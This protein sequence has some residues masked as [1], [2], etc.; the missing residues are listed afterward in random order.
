MKIGL[1][2]HGYLK[3]KKKLFCNCNAISGVKYSEPNS[4]ICPICTAQ[5]GSKPLLPNEDAIKK[6]IKIGLILNCKINEECVWQRKHYDWPDLPKGFQSTISGTYAKPIGENGSFL[7][8]RIR[9]V[10]L[11]EDPAA[12]NPQTGEIDYNRSGLPLIEIVTEPDFRSSKQVVEWLKQ[13]ISTLD[14]IKII[15]KKAGIKADVNVSTSGERV[16]VK[17]VNSLRNIQKT[18]EYEIL[19]QK[20]EIPTI[21]ETRRFDELKGTTKKMRDKEGAED[22]RFLFEPDLPK[23]VLNKRRVLEIKSS[24]PEMPHEKVKKLISK[25]KIPE[26]SAEILTKKLEIVEFFEKVVSKG[27]LKLALRWVTEELLSVL[28]YNKK[29][30]EDVEIEAEHFLELLELLDKDKITEHQAREILRSWIPK[31]FFPSKNL[32]GKE[33]IV[34]EEELENFV[35]EVLKNFPEAVQDYK[36][37]KENALNFLIGQIMKKSKGRADNKIVEKILKRS[38]I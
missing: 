18:I 15:N 19:R 28:N 11:E 14:Y 13:L 2:I 9:E 6:S 1:E 34:D 17:N 37:G 38:I 36:K 5:P 26:N 10:H 24:L 30:L 25:Y 27:K 22:Y 12:W 32:E 31:S 4:N 7:G 16:E 35:K 3:T 8:I 21:Q 23:I 29:E 33:K 20:D